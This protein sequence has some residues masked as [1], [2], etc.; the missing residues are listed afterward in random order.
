[1]VAEYQRSRDEW[2]NVPRGTIGERIGVGKLW[3]SCVK[4]REEGRGKREEGSRI[5]P[6][7]TIWARGSAMRDLWWRDDCLVFDVSTWNILN[8]LLRLLVSSQNDAFSCSLGQFIVFSR[9]DSSEGE[10]M[11]HVE[12]FG[13][14]G[15][16]RG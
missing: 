15:A 16:A 13:I 3:G 5:V 2:A 11:F 4:A 1:M 8:Q 9:I 6:R 10:G 14:R 7:G 12:Q